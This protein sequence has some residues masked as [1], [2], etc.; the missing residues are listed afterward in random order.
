MKP[1]SLMVLTCLMILPVATR[2]QDVEKW[3]FR[4]EA[5]RYTIHRKP[6]IRGN[7]PAGIA[8]GVHL[9]RHLTESLVF[10]VGL[11]QGFGTEAAVR[12]IDPAQDRDLAFNFT[13]V[14]PGIEIQFFPG[15]S[16]SPVVGG[17]AGLMQERSFSTVSATYFAVAGIEGKIG[18][19]QRL[20]L[21]VRR[22]AHPNLGDAVTSPGP[23]WISLSW[24]HLF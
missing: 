20:R 1:L 7:R 8:L 17:G 24:V 15:A 12:S 4:A 18:K 3:R 2:A 13:A 16:V 9:G 23:H 5:G 6:P 11:T 10:E 14:E 22:G 21:S 19:A